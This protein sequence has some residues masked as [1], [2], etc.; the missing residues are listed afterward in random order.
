M[1]GLSQFDERSD[2]LRQEVVSG[3][4]AVV[5]VIWLIQSL[6]RALWRMAGGGGGA[7]LGTMWDMGHLCLDDLFRRCMGGHSHH[8]LRSVRGA[9]VDIRSLHPTTVSK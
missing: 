8:E 7:N 6:A 5:Q 4:I 3:F 9:R 1:S 2:S